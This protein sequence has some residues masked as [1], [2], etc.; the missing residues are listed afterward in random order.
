MEFTPVSLQTIQFETKFV[1]EMVLENRPELI[2]SYKELAKKRHWEIDGEVRD[3]EITVNEHQL[4]KQR[5][6]KHI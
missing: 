2:D 5:R 6:K 3:N 1:S 4:T